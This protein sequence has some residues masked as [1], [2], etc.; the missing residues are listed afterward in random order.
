MKYRSRAGRFRGRDPESQTLL[1]T[2]W[3]RSG[4]KFIVLIIAGCFFFP[5]HSYA[6]QDCGCG[7]Y[8]K[9]A[10]GTTWYTNSTSEQRDYLHLLEAFETSYDSL[11]HFLSGSTSGNYADIFGGR[12]SVSNSDYQSHY[13]EYRQHIM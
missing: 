10:L 9:I 4:M 3:Q 11:Q 6:Q 13:N 1:P 2:S 8:V 12:A 5:G 7:D